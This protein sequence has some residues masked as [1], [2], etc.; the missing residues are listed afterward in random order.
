VINKEADDPVGVIE[1]ALDAMLACEPIEAKI[2]AAEKQGRFQGEPLANVRDLPTLAARLGVI[3]ES[4]FQEMQKRDALRDKVIHVDD[5]PFEI[6][7]SATVASP[8]PH[9]QAA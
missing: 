9:R 7:E 4:E 1:L 8:E 6:R 3:S 5:F 2:R